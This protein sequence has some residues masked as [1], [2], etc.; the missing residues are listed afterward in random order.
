MAFKHPH[1]HTAQQ[2]LRLLKQLSDN[3]NGWHLMEEDQS[4]TH[5]QKA[6]DSYPLLPIARGEAF[7]QG[8]EFAT[9]QVA[10]VIALPSCRK[11]CKWPSYIINKILAVLYKGDEKLGCTEIKVMYRAHEYLFCC[12]F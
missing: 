9:K 5:Y 10:S 7:I 4:I 2:A 11:A 1:T 6:N 12:K 3:L 8:N